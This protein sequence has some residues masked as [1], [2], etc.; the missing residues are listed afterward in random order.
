[1][2]RQ[3]LA[4]DLRRLAH[5]GLARHL[6]G[7]TLRRV[8]VDTAEYARRLDVELEV[9]AR[10]GEVDLLLAASAVAREARRVGIVLAP[11]TWNMGSSL[12]CLGLGLT[13]IDP[14]EHGLIFWR[15]VNQRRGL[16]L[17]VA[18]SRCAELAA[19]TERAHGGRRLLVG[20]S[21]E[22]DWPAFLPME[23]VLGAKDVIPP[24]RPARECLRTRYYHAGHAVLELWPRWNLDVL[25][26]CSEHLAAA[27]A[28]DLQDEAT[29]AELAAEGAVPDGYSY[30]AAEQVHLVRQLA[31]ES[32]E[33]LIAAVSFRLP[34]H[35]GLRVRYLE[36]KRGRRGPPLAH[37]V[38]EKILAP[39]FG[40]LLYAEQALW[41]AHH[42]AG[43]P[44]DVAELFRREVRKGR[45][46]TIIEHRPRFIDGA[47]Q[48]GTDAATAEA[49]YNLLLENDGPP[50]FRAQD[51]GEAIL[52]YRLSYLRVHHP[53]ALAD[54]MNRCGSATR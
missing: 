40:C 48:R 10:L 33:E 37:P 21:D 6:D 17:D 49:V 8:A 20:E 32:F 3:T 30:D 38:V 18:E 42:V 43:Y 47:V 22:R 54:A 4:D 28:T 16:R 7:R 1:M 52:A 25:A 51:L 5:D 2:S 15:C 29:F 14:L 31:P 19:W 45:A 12:V 46:P 34:Y 11:N 36:A 24:E 23:I 35:A 50:F 9:F 41:I 39:T 13:E 53:G 44:L 26:A 27:A